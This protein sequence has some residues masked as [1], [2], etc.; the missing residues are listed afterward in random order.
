MRLPFFGRHPTSEL[1]A[2]L[3]GELIPLRVEAMEVH[4][5]SCQA[6]RS[7]LAGLR[8][9]QADLAA[10]PEV[11]APRSFALTPQMAAGPVR[12]RFREP[13]PPRAAALAYG[14]RL[15]GGAMALALALVLV[16]DFTGSGT[17]SDNT[18]GVSAD[19]VQEVAT[20]QDTKNAYSSEQS[21]AV[22]YDNGGVSSTTAPELLPGSTTGAQGGV[23]GLPSGSGTDGKTEGPQATAAPPPE[24]VAGEPSPVPGD[25]RS[26]P[27][28]NEDLGAVTPEPAKADDAGALNLP[29]SSGQPAV[30]ASSTESGGDIDILT[31]LAVALAAGVALALAGSI[32]VQRIGRNQL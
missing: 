16:L 25:T 5:E 10:L 15:A 17:T 22:A 28:A 30:T 2:Y 13:V 26:T 27:A 9:L 1:S 24:T 8:R 21:P 3:D 18:A 7:E 23:G 31:A 14:M 12:Q 4:L 20:T 11:P 6:C 19:R 32:V 29:H